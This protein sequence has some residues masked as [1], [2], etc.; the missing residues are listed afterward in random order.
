M[1][2]DSLEI[3]LLPRCKGMFSVGDPKMTSAI[4]GGHD[5][6]ATST[7]GSVPTERKESSRSTAGR[8][9]RT[10]KSAWRLEYDA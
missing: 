4:C 7:Q 10:L 3:I 8:G 6:E 9:P 1:S 5:I 2:W